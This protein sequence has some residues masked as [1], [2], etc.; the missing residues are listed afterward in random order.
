MAY[1]A[2]SDAELAAEWRRVGIQVPGELVTE[3]LGRGAKMVPHLGPM[4]A[5]P[6][7]WEDEWTGLHVLML[8]RAVASP[9]AASFAATFLREGLGFEWLTEE[10]HNLVRALGPQGAPAIWEVVED[11]EAD[12]WGRAEGVL[13][14]TLLALEHEP[15]R[16]P[17]A[18]RLR[19]LAGRLEDLK[20]PDEDEAALFN[21]VC[22]SL[23]DLHDGP[24]RDA[25]AQAI[26]KGRCQWEED[27]L[28][29]AYETPFAETLEHWEPGDPTEHFTS[30]NLHELEESS[31]EAESGDEEP[32]PEPFRA[33]ARPGR[34]DPC[35]CGSG[36]KYK[37][38][39][40]QGIS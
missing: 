21:Q 26:R 9:D 38:C 10:G 20:D 31:K 3:T 11:D 16:K 17:T 23:A 25:I 2:L 18:E 8:L 15:L 29:S 36:K 7:V 1:S 30:R 24:S 40:G 35:P 14:L 27:G 4:L 5:D 28:A 19:A 13:G 33:G 22:Y 12:P 34:N 32:G 39:C 37:K 6:G